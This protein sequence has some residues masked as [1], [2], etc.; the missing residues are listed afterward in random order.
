MTRYGDRL[1]GLLGASASLAW[2]AY[3]IDTTR[4]PWSFQAILFYALQIQVAVLF[5]R[6]RDPLAA[7]TR[8]SMW[9]ICGASLVGV[10]LF[11][12]S[13]PS[14]G[15]SGA[16]ADGL[17]LA[18]GTLTILGFATLGKGFGVLPAFRQLASSGPYAVVRHPVYAG[19]L[20]MDCG[21][22]L[23]NRQAVNL[24]VVACNA[25][26]LVARIQKE[27]QVCAA[28][29]PY[30]DYMARVRYRLIPGIY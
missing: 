23:A 28:L 2:C 3:H 4:G 17:T 20:L 7:C 12:F 27:E 8:L 16:V 19:Y 29:G 14:E 24:A 25:S 6:R 1:A 21:I 30:R 10:V 22:L 11:D 9:L 13:A 15:A 26:L 5:V 18:G